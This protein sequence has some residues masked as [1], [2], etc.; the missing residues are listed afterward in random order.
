MLKL[1]ELLI[2]ADGLRSRHGTMF[3]V[4]KRRTEYKKCLVINNLHVLCFS[5][6]GRMSV[7]NP[8]TLLL[9][10]ALLVISSHNSLS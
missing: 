1:T 7:G 9:L 8:L 6:Q 2:W 10:S 3:E 4:M 5:G